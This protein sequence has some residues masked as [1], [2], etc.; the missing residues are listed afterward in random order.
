MGADTSGGSVGSAYG[1]FT[2]GGVLFGDSVRQEI[3]H[4]ELTSD[5]RYSQAKTVLVEV[6]SDARVRQR[7]Y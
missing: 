2:Q 4:L 6:C 1:P 7:A 5:A 3:Y